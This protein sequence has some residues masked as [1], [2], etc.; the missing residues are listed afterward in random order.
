MENSNT[1]LTQWAQGIYLWSLCKST[2]GNWKHLGRPNHRR[3]SNYLFFLHQLKSNE[4]S[5]QAKL[6]HC[7]YLNLSILECQ[8]L[9]LMPSPSACTICFECA[10]F[11][12]HTQNTLA[13]NMWFLF[14]LAVVVLLLSSRQRFKVKASLFEWKHCHISLI[15]WFFYTQ[16]LFL[17]EKQCHLMTFL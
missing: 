17:E 16:Y 1:V 10:Q 2:D 9:K 14:P 5:C 13:R 4:K 7:T 11:F 3:C 6:A 15:W 8:K 12:K